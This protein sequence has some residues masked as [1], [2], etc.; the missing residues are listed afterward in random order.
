[1][2]SRSWLKILELE[3]RIWRRHILC[4]GGIGVRNI[5]IRVLDFEET[6]PM[7]SGSRFEILELL[8]WI[9]KNICYVVGDESSKYWNQGVN[10]LG[11]LL[12]CGGYRFKISESVCWI[13]RKHLLCFGGCWSVILELEC[14]IFRKHL[15]LSKGMGSRY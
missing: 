12:G 4:S 7:F 13:L 10:I 15:P 2:L 5:G 11:H 14:R 1:M 6:P 3:S 8:C 9:W